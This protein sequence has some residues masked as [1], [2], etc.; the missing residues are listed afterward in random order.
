MK[1]FDIET[2]RI[3]L[4]FTKPV[5]HCIAIYDTEDNQ[6][7]L[8]DP[9]HGSIE[10]AFRALNGS[11][12]MAHNG[13]GFDYYVMNLYAELKGWDWWEGVKVP[14][15]S[16]VKVRL[17]F[18][19]EKERDWGRYNKGYLPAKLVGSHSLEAWG[20]RVGDFKGSFGKDG[21]EDVWDKWTPEMSEYMV[22]DV[23]VL[24]ALHEHIEEFLEKDNL[25]WTEA[26]QL[27]HD[28]QAIILRQERF[29][30]LFNE[31]KAQALH[32]KLL[33]RHDALLKKLR[34]IFPPFFMPDKVFVPKSDNKRFGYKKGIPMTK[35]KRW[36]FN[37][38]SGD[39]IAWVFRKKYRWKP[40][41]FNEKS[42]KPKVDETV[43]KGLDFPEVP[44]LL[45]YLVVKKRLEQL[46]NGRQGW[47]KHVGD[48]GRIHGRVNTMGAVTFRMTHSNPNVAQVPAARS[49]Y[50]QECRELFHVPEGR[51]LVGCDAQ[52]IEARCLSH[53]L[54][55]FDGGA[56]AKAVLEGKKS[57]GTD[58]HTINMKAL[59]I[60]SRDDAKTWFYAFIYGAGDETLGGYLGGG[61][62]EGR[63][64]RERFMKRLPAL[65][66]LVKGVQHKAKTQKWIK[67]LD[68][69]RLICRSP[70]SALNTLLQSAGAIIM[71]RALVIADRLFQEAGYIPSVDYEFVA[72]VHDEFQ[73][74]CCEHIAERIGELARKAIVLAGEYY[75]L[76]CPQD[77]SYDIGNSWAE[78]H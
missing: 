76:R 15:D 9:D 63:A 55:R 19:D 73:I 33:E 46:I 27:E 39:H 54:A 28:V 69:R 38:K 49:P 47:M 26:I 50:G 31:E 44:L 62:K 5:I 72:N 53:F 25:D 14:E 77:G 21:G 17:L 40:T 51:K 24:K 12:A 2:N 29:G 48:D 65:G 34:E 37:P 58:V 10:E 6:M 1:L 3:P 70:H 36:N 13:L 8:Y 20:Y 60:S 41:V 57:E 30:F 11:V 43:L 4:V 67:G 42:G 23:F 45:E 52:G 22:Q 71:K 59:V 7:R 74:E 68:G 61:R 18:A 56:Y 75:N 32:V 66:K 64:A 16:L 35:M 78:T